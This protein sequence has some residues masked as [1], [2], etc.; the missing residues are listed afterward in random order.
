MRYVTRRNI[1]R[2][3]SSEAGRSPSISSG[4]D[5]RSSARSVAGNPDVLL[6]ETPYFGWPEGLVRALRDLRRSGIV[7]VLA[8][9]ERNHAIQM[10]P[11]RVGEVIEAGAL[12]QGD[13]CSGGWEA[14]RA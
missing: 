14:W 6:I 1:S 12:V 3:R 13:G 7:P 5:F 2:S 4:G 10:A 11:D 9:P 8:H